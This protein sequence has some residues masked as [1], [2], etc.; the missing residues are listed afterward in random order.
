MALTIFLPFT[1]VAP[2]AK[3]PPAGGGDPNAGVAEEAGAAAPPKPKAGAAP[4]GVG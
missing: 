1:A 2:M 4:A 3:P